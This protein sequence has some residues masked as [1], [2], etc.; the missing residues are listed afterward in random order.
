MPT[1]PRITENR[2][3]ATPVPDVRSSVHSSLDAFGGG[4][5]S[6]QVTEATGAL[7]KQSQQMIL[8]EIA[9]A[10]KIKVRDTTGQ[11][12]AWENEFMN[13]ALQR[14]GENAFSLPDE[15]EDAYKAK[16]EEIGRDL[17]NDYQK[18]SFNAIGQTYQTSMTKRISAHVRG[19]T[20]AYDEEKTNALLT[21][22]SNAAINAFDDDERILMA[23]ERITAIVKDFAS[24]E[25]KSKE[26]EQLEISTRTNNMYKN[27][28]GRK[29][30][31]NPYDLLEKLK[32]GS[33]DD[34]ILADDL[35]DIKED[36]KKYIARS[37]KENKVT[38]KQLQYKNKKEFNGNV[39]K[40]TI[41]EQLNTLELGVTTGAWDK[42]WAVSKKWALLSEKGIDA[43]TQDE[44][45]SD[46]VIGIGDVQSQYKK[47]KKEWAKKKNAQEYLRNINDV[48]IEI[49]NGRGK[50]LLSRADANRLLK[51]LYSSKALDGTEEAFKG[52]SWFSWGYDDA[53]NYFKENLKEF[54]RE[55]ALRDYFNKVDGKDLDAEKKKEI[56]KSIV[57]DSV[58][59]EQIKINPNRSKYQIDKTYTE[60]NG[61]FKVIDFDSDGEPIIETQ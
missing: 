7:F 50:G 60:A 53:N 15:F 17:S 23:T 5:S 28:L 40:T 36:T 25:G 38:L 6:R 16:M 42:K 35:G 48:E 14:S 30:Q 37:E 49:N 57:D 31:E 51:S 26:W 43:N 32:A 11:L 22:E 24:N 8:E 52:G 20:S 39:E 12:A 10:N 3:R 27:I 46:I 55:K 33:Y 47:E 4:E 59:K 44:Y 34:L 58:V 21:N 13:D 56:A 29:M 1:V 54:E 61:S 2:V 18:K 45:Y 41:A 19:Q 9:R